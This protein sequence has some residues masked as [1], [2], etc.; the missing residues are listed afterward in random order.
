M[1]SG[2]KKRRKNVFKQSKSYRGILEATGTE[3]ASKRAA[4]LSAF[5][6]EGLLSKLQHKSEQRG[7]IQWVSF[8]REKLYEHLGKEM[9]NFL[10]TQY[11]PLWL[12]Q[13]EG[14]LYMLWSKGVI[15]KQGYIRHTMEV[16]PGISKG[17]A[18]K[19]VAE[20]F[21]MKE[22]TQSVYLSDEFDLR[23]KE[24]EQ[25]VKKRR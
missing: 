2:I 4:A 8:P 6:R 11:D 9:W 25:S 13:F 18:I 15:S 24:H 16:M 7:G 20:S 5:V 1:K 3:L 21:G 22:S 23:T 19:L 14:Y 12:S 17:A 10:I